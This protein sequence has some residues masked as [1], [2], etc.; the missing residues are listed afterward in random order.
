MVGRNHYKGVPGPLPIDTNLFSVK[1]G[2]HLDAFSRLRFSE[3][4]VLFDCAL[5]HSKQEIFW[6]E[7]L[8]GGATSTW[9][10][11]RASL[12][13]SVGTAAGDLAF[14]Q[15]KEYFR[16]Q[17]GK[18]H[19]VL[20]TAILGSSKVNVRCRVG[21]FDDNNGMFFEQTSAGV[22]AVIRSAVSGTP[23]DTVVAQAAWN[24]DPFDGTGPS[25]KTLDLSKI[26]IFVIDFQWLGAGR[27]RFGFFMD[28]ALYYAHEVAHANASDE[29]YISDP[30]LPSRFEI[31]NTGVSA[32]ATTLEQASTSVISEGGHNPKGVI[33][34]VDTGNSTVSLSAGVRVPVISVRL[35]DDSVRSSIVPLAYTV[36]STSNDTIH[37]ELVFNG[38]LENPSWTTLSGAS[39]TEYDQTATTISSGTVVWSDY[40]SQRTGASLIELEYAESSV[41]L[42]ATASGV[43][44][45]YSIAVTPVSPGTAS[46]VAALNFK[47]LE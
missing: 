19:L 1:D 30:N 13:L 25:R 24:I 47:E 42:A 28:G 7:V 3:P 20:Q 18:S 2:A 10:D 16:Y 23:V 29:V 21:Y 45:I 17:P 8:Y 6:D 11:T 36:L 5:N 15:T 43:A 41:T 44:D 4:F 40:T 33:R 37:V 46:V 26:Q 12:S 39:I 38:I 9:N 14:R 22:S 27:V 34:A 35:T 32:S 31:E